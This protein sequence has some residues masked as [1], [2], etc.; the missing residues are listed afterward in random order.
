[1]RLFYLKG[2]AIFEQVGLLHCF[3]MPTSDDQFCHISFERCFVASPSSNL[4]SCI[5]FERF[6]FFV[7]ETGFLCL[8][9]V[10]LN[11][12]SLFC[13]RSFEPLAALGERF[14]LVKHDTS[15]FIRGL[16]SPLRF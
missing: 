16:L 2:C 11:V 5:S 8:E 4:F 7:R 1:M 13:W 14:I 10:F 9:D 12:M 3:A 15:F 6:V